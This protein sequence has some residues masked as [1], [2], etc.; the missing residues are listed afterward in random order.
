M[1]Y[2]IEYKDIKKKNN[3]QENALKNPFENS[4]LVVRKIKSESIK[5]EYDPDDVRGAFFVN[6]L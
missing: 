2:V 4:G 1:F 6:L 3:F 5:Y